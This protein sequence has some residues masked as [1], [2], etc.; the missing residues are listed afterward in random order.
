[1]GTV[2]ASHGQRIPSWTKSKYRNLLDFCAF[3]TSLSNGE[4]NLLSLLPVKVIAV[5]EG[6]EANLCLPVLNA[7]IWM[8]LTLA[9][10]FNL[11]A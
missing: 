9:K 6:R 5:H 7:G 11:G 1:M 2:A 8:E 4:N 10:K 3:E